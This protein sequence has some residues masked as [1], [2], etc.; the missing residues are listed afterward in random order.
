MAAARK[1]YIEPN[2]QTNFVT[3]Y[4]VLDSLHGRI[5]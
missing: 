2:A 3:S 4:C 1:L 5:G